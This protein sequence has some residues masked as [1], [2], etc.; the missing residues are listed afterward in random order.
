MRTVCASAPGKLVLSGEY[1]VLDGAAA[2][3]VALDHRAKV[4]IAPGNEDCHTIYSPGYRE[5]TARFVSRGGAIHLTDHAADH[6]LFEAIWMESGISPAQPIEFTLDTRAFRD[7]D[8]GSK[9]GIG[10][11]A[12]LSAAL[13]TALSRLGGNE[14]RAVAMLGH[15]RFQGGSGSGVDVATSL[16]GGVIQYR[17]GDDRPRALQWPEGLNYE[18]LWSGTAADTRA[19]LDIGDRLGE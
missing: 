11:S 13:A 6:A 10:S 7:A 12:A 19:R 5:H 3:A 14:P 9:L 1:A 8:S 16:S 17:L 18:V 2:I 4:S 15:R